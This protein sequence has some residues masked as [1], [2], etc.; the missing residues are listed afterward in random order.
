MRKQQTKP[1]WI[2]VR[3]GDDSNW[4]LE[5]TSD[6]LGQAPPTLGVLDP[7]QVT[8]FKE[9]LD[10]YREY[11]YRCA[12]FAAAFRPFVLDAE[13]DEG[14]LRLAASQDDIFE[15]RREVFGL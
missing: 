10:E 7:Q 9:A 6:E 12:Q 5:H 8:Y 4:W 14:R 1:Q 15:A 11:G 13:I 3:L 2:V